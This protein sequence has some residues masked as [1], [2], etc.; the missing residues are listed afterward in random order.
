MADEQKPVKNETAEAKPA[1]KSKSTRA[2]RKKKEFAYRGY[3]LVDLQKMS[4]EDLANVLPARARRCIKRGFS[5]DV[6][7]FLEKAR[8]AP[9]D[10]VLKTHVRSVIILPELV[11]RRV[12][13]HNGKEFKEIT[14]STEMIGHY[15]GEF[16]PPTMSFLRHSNPGVGATRGSKFLPLK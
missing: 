6:Q 2:P 14:I 7:I 8:K 4:L 12:A 9:Q 13:I 3:E 15:L 11:G 5:N 1:R 16:A 10:K